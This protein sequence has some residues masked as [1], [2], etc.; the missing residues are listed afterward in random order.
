PCG[1]APTRRC[2][3]ATATGVSWP[4]RRRG[5]RGTRRAWRQARPRRR[6]AGR[7]RSCSARPTPPARPASYSDAIYPDIRCQGSGGRPREPGRD[8]TPIAPTV[9]KAILLGVVL[10]AVV[11]GL[12]RGLDMEP[13]PAV[14][15]GLGLTL[16]FY[17]VVLF[18]VQGRLFYGAVKPVWHI[19]PP[20]TG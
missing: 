3:P 16:S 11:Y 18:M 7:A 4:G 1:R 13:A 14:V 2:P 5:R 17:L 12:S 15:L 10:Q 6:G 19:G 20:G 9:V 8:R